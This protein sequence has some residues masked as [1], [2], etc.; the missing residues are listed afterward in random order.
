MGS[1]GLEFFLCRRD[2]GCIG[3]GGEEEDNK[4]E[5]EYACEEEGCRARAS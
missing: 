1:R 5:E 4:A 3:R 2:G